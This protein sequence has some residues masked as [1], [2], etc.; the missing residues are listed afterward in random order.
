MESINVIIDDSGATKFVKSNDNDIFGNMS[1]SNNVINNF[2]TR[3]IM[4]PVDP[5][6]SFDN[7]R[8]G[9]PEDLSLPKWANKA[10]YTD[11]IIGNLK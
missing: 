9:D 1:S 2:E 6:K 4:T 3:P 10:H 8:N 5:P 7:E 11:N